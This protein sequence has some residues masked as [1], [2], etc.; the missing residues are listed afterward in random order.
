MP[1]RDKCDCELNRNQKLFLYPPV[2]ICYYSLDRCHG[3][4]RKNQGTRCSR[5]KAFEIGEGTL[6]IESREQEEIHLKKSLEFAN[7]EGRR[8]MWYN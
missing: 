3:F 7:I 1:L 5:W 2:R 6:F 4:R 8:R